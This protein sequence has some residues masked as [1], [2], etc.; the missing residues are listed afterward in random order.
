MERLPHVNIDP[1]VLIEKLKTMTEPEI[2]AATPGTNSAQI[3]QSRPYSGVG[4]W[5]ELLKMF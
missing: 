1:E 2:I 4:C 3:R 5:V